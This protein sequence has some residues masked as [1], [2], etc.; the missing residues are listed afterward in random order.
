MFRGF[1]EWR[2]TWLGEGAAGEEGVFI[3]SGGA[4]DKAGWGW[5]QME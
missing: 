1:G 4:R 2:S 3:G 5:W